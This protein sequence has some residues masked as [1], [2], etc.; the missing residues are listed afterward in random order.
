MPVGAKS[1]KLTRVSVVLHAPLLPQ[2]GRHG[3]LHAQPWSFNLFLQND[4][5][6]N[7]DALELGS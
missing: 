5:E 6:V 7:H 2:Q 4:H 1:A 3:P